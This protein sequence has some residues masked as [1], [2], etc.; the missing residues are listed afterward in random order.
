MPIQMEE[1]QIILGMVPAQGGEDY[2]AMRAAEDYRGGIKDDSGTGGA[3]GASAQQGMQL[4]QQQMAFIPN[5]TPQ[6]EGDPSMVVE[7]FLTCRKCNSTDMIFRKLYHPDPPL[8]I[9]SC[10][11]CSQQIALCRVCGAQMNAVGGHLRRHMQRHE[12]AMMQNSMGFAMVDKNAVIKVE[13]A[14]GGGAQG[15]PAQGMQSATI[16]TIPSGQLQGQMIAGDGSSFG[17]M[18]AQGMKQ[19]CFMVMPSFPS[20]LSNHDHDVLRVFG[21]TASRWR[22]CLRAERKRPS[23]SRRDG[24]ACDAHILRCYPHATLVSGRDWNNNLLFVTADA[25]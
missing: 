15:S 22:A 14:K 5:P 21:R 20:P 9:Y 6:M 7:R 25:M 19:V 16:F 1:S 23:G 18:T 4:Q 2:S 3:Q 17:I 12:K 24:R 8:E 10:A 13:P 11:H